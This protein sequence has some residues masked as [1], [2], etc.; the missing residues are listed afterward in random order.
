[1]GIK[2]VFHW[3]ALS[4][5]GAFSL[6]LFLS[7]SL[8]LVHTHEIFFSSRK[9][10]ANF[11]PNSVNF[12]FENRRVRERKREREIKEGEKGREREREMASDLR[13]AHTNE[14]KYL[15]EAAKRGEE[16]TILPLL[17]ES[18]CPNI[19]DSVCVCVCVCVFGSFLTLFSLFSLSPHR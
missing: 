3:M 13:F 4:S 6:S 1:M 5:L 8:S 10:P 9:T 15:L 17:Q 2:C 12:C 7:I 16:K 18:V 14:E 19:H 11:C